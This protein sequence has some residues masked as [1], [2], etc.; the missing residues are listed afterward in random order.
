[1]T[2]ADAIRAMTDEE[3]VELMNRLEVGDIDYSQTFCC[4]CGGDS[5]DMPCDNCRL[6]WLH[7]ESTDTYFGLKKGGAE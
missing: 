5:T 2:N 6:E 1:M 7:K 4:L 3:L